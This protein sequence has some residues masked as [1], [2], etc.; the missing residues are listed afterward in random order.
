[1]QQSKIFAQTIEPISKHRYALRADATHNVVAKKLLTI[2][3][4]KQTNLAVAADVTTKA[5]LLAL[6]D[7]VG[8]E[9]CFLKT[10]I[11]IIQDFDVDLVV[12]LKQLAK[13]HNF[14]IVEDRKFADIG[15]T[16]Q[17]QYAGG[18]YR[19]V[20]WADIII[21]HA[22]SGADII[23]A[24]QLSADG[25]ERGVLLIAHLSS[26]GNLIDDTYTAQ[27]VTM[28][29]EYENFVIGFIAQKSLT[30]MPNFITCT[31]GVSI[32]Q[33]KDGLGQQYNSPDYVI[34]KQNS[35]VVIVGRAV[36]QAKDPRAVA[37]HY[38]T[39]A[40]QAYLERIA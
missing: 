24:L 27:V 18:I 35:D 1:M 16:V 30:D 33:Q 11:D 13:K 37:H 20:E 36:Y 32:A 6:A 2:M 3:H 7:A 23:K 12:Q 38:R 10:H 40:W 4:T 17:Q 34:K 28:A 39:V 25:Y 9:I 31:P 5:E 15:S 14:L 22:I 8:P 29:R 21:A 26:A 19:I